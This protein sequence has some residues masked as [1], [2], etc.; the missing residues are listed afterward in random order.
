M[1]RDSCPGG[2]SCLSFSLIIPYQ[3]PRSAAKN[4]A[5]PMVLSRPWELWSWHLRHANM[6]T[7]HL[8]LKT[9]KSS[10]VTLW[11]SPTII[12][13][14]SNLSKL[15]NVICNYNSTVPNHEC[16]MRQ[17]HLQHSATRKMKRS[18]LPTIKTGSAN[19]IKGHSMIFVLASQNGARAL[20]GIR[21]TH[22][23]RQ[24]LPQSEKY[25]CCSA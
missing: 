16:I 24:I 21:S 5:R 17:H 2:W 8:Q 10:K 9:E 25:R 11:R 13:H 3:Q 12:M 20:D 18:Y 14:N 19:P 1:C 4:A 15:S 6:F 23:R 22:P 7:T